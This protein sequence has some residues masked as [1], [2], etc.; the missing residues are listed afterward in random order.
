MAGNIFINCLR[1][2]AAGDARG[3]YDRLT[4]QFG[5]S[6][7]LMDVDNLLAGERSGNCR[8]RVIRGESWDSGVAGLR[9]A[10]RGSY[11]LQPKGNI[12]SKLRAI[13][14]GNTRATKSEPW[15]HSLVA[16]VSICFRS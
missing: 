14:A 4:G 11:G 10:T 8:E 1:E 5:K 7:V 3:I 12:A 2:D 15:F 9:S 16:S 6:N 13:L